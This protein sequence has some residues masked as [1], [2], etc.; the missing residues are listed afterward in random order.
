MFVQTSTVPLYRHMWE[1]M[2]N[3]ERSPF[4]NTTQE[5]VEKVRKSNGKYAFLLE[6]AMNDYYNSQPPCD[7]M[8]VGSLLDSKSYGIGVSKHLVEVR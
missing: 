2:R 4:A 8:M 6:S 3:S 7:T 5:G 1:F